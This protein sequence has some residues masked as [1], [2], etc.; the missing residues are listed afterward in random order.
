MFIFGLAFYH[1][2][3]S[4]F[5]IRIKS[6]RL[7]QT[8]KKFIHPKKNP[9]ADPQN[10]RTVLVIQIECNASTLNYD[11]KKHTINRRKN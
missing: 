1:L 3:Q 2:V 7:E 11:I 9:P 10:K 5:K 6:K 8:Q 4:K